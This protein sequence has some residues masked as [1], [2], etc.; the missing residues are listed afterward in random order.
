[1]IACNILSR[2]KVNMVYCFNKFFQLLR[3]STRHHSREAALTNSNSGTGC[4][5]DVPNHGTFG[6]EAA[7]T[8]GRKRS[9]TDWTG[10]SP[11]VS[12]P[13][14]IK[15]RRKACY[16]PVTS[17]EDLPSEMLEMILQTLDPKSFLTARRV[18]HRWRSVAN[19]VSNFSTSGSNPLDNHETT[20]RNMYDYLWYVGKVSE[21][22]NFGTPFPVGTVHLKGHRMGSPARLI[23][24]RS[25]CG[26]HA[27]FFSTCG[28]FLRNLTIT[29]LYLTKMDVL[30]MLSFASC[31]KSLEIDCN[32]CLPAINQTR[33]HDDRAY[34]EELWRN[35]RG[36]LKRLEKLHF[37]VQT[38]ISVHGPEDHI[39]FVNV[40]E[41]ENE[42]FLLRSN[43]VIFF[44]EILKHCS[45][46]L[47]SL[48]VRGVDIFR[49][50]TIGLVDNE[51]FN[52]VEKIL[53]KFRKLETLSLKI[54]SEIPYVTS[55]PTCF[56][57]LANLTINFYCGDAVTPLTQEHLR[58]LSRLSS[59]LRFLHLEFFVGSRQENFRQDAFQQFRMKMSKLKE[60]RLDSFAGHLDFLEGFS[61]TLE[62]LTLRTQNEEIQTIFK[63][64]D[65]FF[66]KLP[67]L[68]ELQID[69][70]SY[71]IK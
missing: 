10:T 71:I 62:Q 50:A 26:H 12:N 11:A 38:K 31:L 61:E 59:S 60:L 67:K 37:T 55:I 51:D 57:S 56:P 19:Y 64:R 25:F 53:S 39:Y 30:K 48:K 54:S 41:Q 63:R 7:M 70:T 14:T 47:K 34:E 40:L 5:I 35:V 43:F 9:T 69:W 6:V 23:F 46:S 4:L 49:R 66:K 24:Y 33:N 2:C 68:M 36:N 20:L 8:Q 29:E 27:T 3:R 44:R 13:L 16:P 58:I 15:R 32:W 1:M 65:V 42:M 22:P 45:L 18:C 28:S 21:F 52:K 17:I